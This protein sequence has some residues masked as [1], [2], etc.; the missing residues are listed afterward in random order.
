MAASE[1][2]TSALGAASGLVADT[3]SAL[4]LV[5]RVPQLDNRAAQL[6]VPNS[7]NGVENI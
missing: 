1:C 7:L 2:G 3:L 4:G 6:A 5:R